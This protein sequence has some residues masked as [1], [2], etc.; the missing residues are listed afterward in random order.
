MEYYI[1]QMEINLK[2]YLKMVRLMDMVYFILF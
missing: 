1:V 2:E